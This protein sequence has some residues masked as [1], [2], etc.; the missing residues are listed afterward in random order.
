[1]VC[2]GRHLRSVLAGAACG[3]VIAAGAGGARAAGPLRGDPAAVALAHA[4]E[5]A[6]SRVTSYSEV[7]HDFVFMR[8]R[9]GRHGVFSWSWGRG[10][11]PAG[12][13]H[14]TEHATV[15]LRAGRVVWASDVLVPD[16]LAC[17]MGRCVRYP[18]VEVLVDSHGQ[19][20]RFGVTGCFYGLTGSVPLHPGE[21]AYSVSGFV[22]DPL[23]GR[24]TT[25]L[26]YLYQ[27]DA[28]RGAG[29]TD[30][31]DNATMLVSSGQTSLYPT[32]GDPHFVFSFSLAYPARRPAP[33]RVR[34]CGS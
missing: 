29:E 2:D 12:W 9:A 32:A 5:R 13:V 21:L 20:F 8:A 1:M 6:F 10:A 17:A 19:F 26:R 34:L 3:A 27:W 30:V 18:S 24:H 23:H 7:E 28:E 15:D 25:L 22:L 31:V 14:A 4:V 33:P 11:A 16:R